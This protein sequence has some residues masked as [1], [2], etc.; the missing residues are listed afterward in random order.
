LPNSEAAQAHGGDPALEKSLL[1]PRRNVATA[2]IGQQQ[3]VV[4]VC[5]ECQEAVVRLGYVALWARK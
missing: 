5:E 3:T 4:P 1:L 2:A